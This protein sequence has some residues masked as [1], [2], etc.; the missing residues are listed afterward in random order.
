MGFIYS[1]DAKELAK[2]YYRGA[3]EA[4]KVAKMAQKDSLTAANIAHKKYTREV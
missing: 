1:A 4:E 2:V 3:V